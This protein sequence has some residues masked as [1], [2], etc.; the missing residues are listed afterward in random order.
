MVP[1][2]TD[3]E[4]LKRRRVDKYLRR[5]LEYDSAEERIAFVERECAATPELRGDLLALLGNDTASERAIQQAM[6]QR[7]S[8]IGDVIADDVNEVSAGKLIG[9]VIGNYRIIRLVGTGGMGAVYLAERADGQFQQTAAI[10]ILPAWAADHQTVARLR[11]ERQILS[12]LQHPNITQLLSGGET[13]DGFPYLVTEYIDGLSITDYVDQH[14]LSLDARLS[15]FRDL[16]DAVHHA[17]T[18]LIV[19]R[20]IKPSNILVD[21]DG[22]PHLLDFG[23]AKLLDPSSTEMTAL[24]T[25][26]GF[27]PMT[28]QY[29]SPEQLRGESITT[30]SDIY[31]LGLLFY[32]LLTGRSPDLKGSGTSGQPAK[33]STV[34][35]QFATEIRGDLDTIVLKALRAEP[36]ER[37]ASAAEMASDVRR[38][39]QGQAI[40]ARRE[41]AIDVTRR[42]AR[43][44]PFG[45]IAAATIVGL[46]IFW[47]TSM[48]LY[49]KRLETER[50]FATQQATRAARVKDV[51]TGVFRR[52]DPLQ[53]DAIGD[54]SASLWDSLD[55]S[56]DQVATQ[57][58]AEPDIQAE[59]YGIFAS[60][61]VGAGFIPNAID[62]TRRA[63]AIYASFGADGLPQLVVTKAELAGLLLNDEMQESQR[64]LD[65][66]LQLL[67]DVAA[68]HPVDAVSALIQAA[69]I[70]HESANRPR[71]IEYF[72]QAQA[73]YDKHQLDNPS[74]YIEILFGIGNSL[75]AEDRLS[76]AEPLLQSALQLAEAEFSPGHARLTGVLGALSSLERN[77]GNLNLAVE[78][79]NRVVEIMR[80]SR[81]NNYENLLTARN[82]LA[83]ALGKAGDYD[84]SITIL[85]EIVQVRREMASDEGSANLATSIKNLAS[86]QHMGGRYDAALISAQESLV[87]MERH[88]PRDSAYQAMPHFTLALIYLDTG[89]AT[90]AESAA[91]QSLSLLL[92]ILGPDHYQIAV[93]RCVIG[94]SLLAQGK[95][96]AAAELIEPSLLALRASGTRVPRYE[97]RCAAA[98]G[99]MD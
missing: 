34:A 24:H 93:N 31:Q 99:F 51:L 69:L 13:P 68:S 37:Y 49:S 33:P 14:K 76:E 95:A 19:H 80:R 78:Y 75:V 47:G 12:T 23:I 67:P 2:D 32:Q 58:S 64:L 85:E 43:N 84:T 60:L 4:Q 71:A 73:I 97:Q 46:V 82:N 8:I 96:D 94:E 28:I 98:H 36:G 88:L 70:S 86:I 7:D 44:N 11:A 6:E 59:L 83:L 9:S 27:S 81:S 91:R 5:A 90:A 61:Y 50:D 62:V 72:R 10:K 87:L 16:T 22:R 79:S 26:A 56:V 41:S 15:L 48:Q 38:F 1:P 40:V 55:V 53:K 63:E 29:A 66:V 18:K 21:T 54:K 30:A 57:L 65:E 3:A 45:A 77:R 42:L 25:V 35:S 20:D 92:P 52:H 89:D 39:Q 74:Q 17:H